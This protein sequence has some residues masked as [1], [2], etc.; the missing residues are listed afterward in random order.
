MMK[1]KAD[2]MA[3]YADRDAG[4]L[5]TEGTVVGKKAVGFINVPVF[6]AMNKPKV[7][8]HKVTQ[9]VHTKEE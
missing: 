6:I 2:Q 4:L 8:S 7:G 3:N 1:P 9:A 5:I